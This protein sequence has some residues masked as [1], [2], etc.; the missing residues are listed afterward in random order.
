MNEYGVEAQVCPQ[1]ECILETILP[2]LNTPQHSKFSQFLHS[3]LPHEVDSSLVAQLFMIDKVIKMEVDLGRE[4]N[5]I[6]TLSPSYQK[7]VL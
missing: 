4:L 7:I 1:E 2:P 3:L 5:V 6:N